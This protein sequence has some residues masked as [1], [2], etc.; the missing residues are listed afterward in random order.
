MA[1]RGLYPYRHGCSISLWWWRRATYDGCAIS[2][3][4]CTFKVIQYLTIEYRS[5]VSK[6]EFFIKM[7][8]AFL[9][10]PSF[11]TQGRMGASKVALILMKNSRFDRTLHSWFISHYFL[12]LLKLQCLVYCGGWCIFFIPWVLT[13][14]PSSNWTL[15]WITISSRNAL[16][17]FFPGFLVAIPFSNPVTS[18]QAFCLGF[19]ISEWSICHGPIVILVIWRRSCVG[20][21]SYPNLHRQGPSSSRYRGLL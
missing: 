19:S 15:S 13:L 9:L 11:I 17:K 7:R 21:T 2:F 4:I 8:A 12:L 20:S 5:V 3:T 1:R 14:I 6:W 16:H 18:I 10:Y